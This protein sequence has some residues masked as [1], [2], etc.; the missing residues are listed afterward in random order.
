MADP[1]TDGSSPSRVTIGNQEEAAE[2][3]VERSV[4]ALETHISGPIF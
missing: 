1:E 4:T 3:G 2:G